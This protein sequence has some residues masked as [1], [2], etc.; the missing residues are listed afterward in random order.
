M[1]NYV[2]TKREYLRE[3]VKG[4][5]LVREEPITLNNEIVGNK[6]YCLDKGIEIEIAC[7]HKLNNLS[8]IRTENE[9]YT[10]SKG[11][12]KASD[13]FNEKNIL[14]GLV[15]VPNYTLEGTDG[16]G[17]STV[18]ESLMDEGIVCF[19]RN[20]DVICKYMLF[21]VSME[22]RVNEYRKYLE[23]TKDKILFLVNMDEEELRKRI[24]SRSVISEFDKYAVE[25]NKLYYDTYNVMKEKGYLNN[26]LHLLDC[27]NLSK[28]EQINAVKKMV[29]R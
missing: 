5:I 22:K 11:L 12:V 21:D 7:Y 1:L 29:L 26:K 16:I 4:L 3:Y 14:N 27:T 19:D 10:P 6:Y 15:T 2:S 9:G 17:K 24:Y 28:E 20:L 13:L 8:V 23:S 25:Y 18:I